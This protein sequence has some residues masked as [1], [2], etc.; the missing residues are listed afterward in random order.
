MS[1]MPHA[2]LVYTLGLVRFPAV[3]MNDFAPLFHNAMRTKMPHLDDIDLKQMR[4]DFGPD[5]A[6]VNHS[7]IKIWQIA[8]PDRGA[9]LVLSPESLALHTTSYKEHQSFLSEFKNALSVL[10]ALLCS[11]ARP[12]ALPSG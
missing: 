9:A 3:P 1:H 2:P 12:R 6:K 7:D 8:S 5:G 11:S 4:V 10:V